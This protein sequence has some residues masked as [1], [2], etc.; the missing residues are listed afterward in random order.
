MDWHKLYE[1][2]LMTGEEAIDRYVKNNDTI[3]FGAQVIASVPMN[4]LFD[5]VKAGK[6]KGITLVGDLLVDPL[7]LD[8]PDITPEKLRYNSVFFG[9]YERKGYAQGNVAFIP[10]QF[11]N[12]TKI[13]QKIRPRVAILPFAPPDEQGYANIG[14]INADLNP[15]VIECCEVLIGQ[16][17]KNMPAACGHESL[18][19]H[20][21]RFD[22]IIEFDQPIPEFPT[23]EITDID[24]K[25]A[26][27]IIDMIPDGATIQ[28]GLGGMANAIG[29]GLKDKK[30]LGVHTEM[31]TESMAYLTKIGV[32]DNSRKTF[33]PGVSVAGFV[34]GSKE[35]Y[36]F[37]NM[38]E[39]T[40]F[41]PF[42]FVNNVVNIMK[43][44][45]MISI[46]NALEVDLYGQVSSEGFGFR[47]YSGTGGQVDYV[48]GALMSKGGKSFIALPS[49]YTDKAGNV[50]SRIV[51]NFS[52]GTPVT[53]LRS[54][55]QYV[56]TEYGCVDLFGEDLV[57]RAKRLISIAHP[58]FR[59]E[60]MFQ[61]KKNY[62]IY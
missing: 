10:T 55:V 22:A 60:L 54:D 37:C 17:N 18:K 1:Q 3:G 5:K 34:L 35:L 20:V 40:Y 19:V 46:N 24:R 32:I 2:K 61:A 44:D 8:D 28:L 23:G 27:Y 42:S 49:T 6:L 31:F 39:G 50:H 52:P 57:T 36:E 33:M 16:M 26:S 21:S 4:A 45:N 62:L 15:A 30:H 47:H 48:R 25:V 43:N 14:P 58:Q 13:I 12:Y 38:N 51:L 53:T 9:K 59:D 29:Y 11:N 41:G 56:V 7:P